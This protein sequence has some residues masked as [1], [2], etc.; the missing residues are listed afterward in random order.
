MKQIMGFSL[1][2]AVF[3]SA[4]CQAQYLPTP[5]QESQAWSEMVVDGLCRGQGKLEMEL[6][7][8]QGRL[9]EDLEHRPR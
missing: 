1:A 4:N 2:L 7:P 8:I 9:Q 6:R 5:A 3:S